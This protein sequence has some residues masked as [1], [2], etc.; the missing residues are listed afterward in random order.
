MMCGRQPGGRNEKQLGICP[1]TREVRL[2]DVHEGCNAGRACWVVAGSLC[3]GET[4]GAFAQKFKNCEKC[5]FYQK[6]KQEEGSRFTLS[7]V[8]L[9]LLRNKREMAGII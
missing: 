2:N 4:Q 8:L 7:A 3:G 9:G 1:V 6:V 5:D